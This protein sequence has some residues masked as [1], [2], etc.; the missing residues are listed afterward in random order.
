[1]W[2]GSPYTSHYLYDIAPA[3]AEVCKEG[4][5]QVRLI[6]AGSI[7][8]P[9]VPFETFPWSEETE[10]SLIQECHVGIMPLTD[11]PWERGKCGF[12]LIQYMGCS[13]PVIA[14]PVGVNTEIVDEGVNG[15]LASSKEEWIEKLTTLRNSPSL[16][17]TIGATGRKKVEQ[18]YSLQVWHSQYVDIIK[19]IL[20]KEKNNFSTRA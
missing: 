20:D 7:D 12:K 8:L 10:V 18:E 16:S 5:A 11:S 15:Y 9:N 14:S 6:G 3:L 4:K 1:M 13:L 17:T 19:S 2:I